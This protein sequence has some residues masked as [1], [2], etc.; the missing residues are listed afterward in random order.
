MR[1]ALALGA[2]WALAWATAPARLA[3]QGAEPVEIRLLEPGSGDRWVV[4]DAQVVVVAV[5]YRLPESYV[6]LDSARL[7]L[8]DELRC[9][10]RAGSLTVGD[11]TRLA[12][13]DSVALRFPV[14]AAGSCMAAGLSSDADDAEVTVWYYQPGEPPDASTAASLALPHSAPVWSPLLGALFGVLL[15][16]AVLFMAVRTGRLKPASSPRAFWSEV[17]FGAL[18]SL[19]V[20]LL[21]RLLAPGEQPL[22]VRAVLAE[23]FGHGLLLGLGYHTAAVGLLAFIHRKAKDEAAPS[24]P[25]PTNNPKGRVG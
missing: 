15:A 6:I 1:R 20:V 13:G 21:V 18:V 14:P 16:N 23:S 11:D 2:L 10:G 22:F 24:G 9:G 17:S 7:V 3:A 19:V 12:P 5:A 8:P 25:A 4:S